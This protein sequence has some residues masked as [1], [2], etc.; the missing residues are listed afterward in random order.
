[1]AD[2]QSLKLTLKSSDPIV[3]NYVRDL[4]SEILKLQK[5]NTKLECTNMSNKH[6]IFAL[7]KKLNAYFKK[8]H[9]TVVTTS[10]KG[11]SKT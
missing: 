11:G 1:M 4:E 8:G 7:Q 3:R 2:S 9:V 5:Q 6:K 10:Y